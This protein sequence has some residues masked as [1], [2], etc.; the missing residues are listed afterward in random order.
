MSNK[1]LSV[2]EAKSAG[3]NDGCTNNGGFSNSTSAVS[4]CHKQNSKRVTIKRQIADT[5]V[6]LAL[7]MTQH[8]DLRHHF[9][10]AVPYW[11]SFF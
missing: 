10:G 3:S 8:C 5:V 4:S 7:A 9:L 11:T 1:N 6:A 2:K